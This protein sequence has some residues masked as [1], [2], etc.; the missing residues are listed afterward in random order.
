MLLLQSLD[1]ALQ[2][3]LQVLAPVDLF[4]Q[5]PVFFSHG[6]DDAS[7]VANLLF[8]LLVDLQGPLVLALQVLKV[9]LEGRK[10]CHQIGQ[11]PILASYGFYLVASFVD[12]QL[13]SDLLV[14]RCDV[15][16]SALRLQQAGLRLFDDDIEAFDLSLLSMRL[17]LHLSS[18]LLLILQLPP[19]LHDLALIL[20]LD[21]LLLLLDGFLQVLVPPHQLMR[22]LCFFGQTLVLLL[23][24]THLL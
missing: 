4:N 12:A 22:L 13:A 5:A 3:R 20:H 16:K 6:I 24:V 23:Q 17:L 7:V 1:L 2:L 9:G 18:G 8:L 14:S 19:Q 21:I 11:R 15:L 10:C